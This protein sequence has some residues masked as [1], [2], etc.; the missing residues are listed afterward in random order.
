MSNAIE[1]VDR[2]VALWN[3]PDADR[4]RTEIV[5]LWAP[6]GV[7]FAKSYTC[8][9][10]TALEDRVTRSY[11]RSIAPGVHVFRHLGNVESHHDVVR[12]NW[13]MARRDTGHVAAVGFEFFVLADDGRIA[14]DYQ[15]I[16]RSE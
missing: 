9:G 14:A 3:E 6:G 5:A 12:F 16:D 15:F 8:H 7:H 1:L 13:H 10:Y 4:R 2:Y 11:A